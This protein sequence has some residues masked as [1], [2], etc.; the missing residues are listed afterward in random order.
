MKKRITISIDEK[1]IEKLRKIQAETIHKESRTVSF[2][3]VV[4]SVLEKGLMC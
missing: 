2:S 3:E 4:C 1:T